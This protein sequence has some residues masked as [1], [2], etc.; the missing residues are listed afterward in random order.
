MRAIRGPGFW[1]VLTAVVTERDE[2]TLA[3][4]AAAYDTV[5]RVPFFLQAVRRA[6]QRLDRRRKRSPGPSQQR[7]EDVA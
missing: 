2:R 6:G 5:S 3:E 4:L 7:R 1:S